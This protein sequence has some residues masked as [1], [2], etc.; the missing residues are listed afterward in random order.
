VM[1]HLEGK[2]FLNDSTIAFKI[3]ADSDGIKK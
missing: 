2:F 3:P 1:V